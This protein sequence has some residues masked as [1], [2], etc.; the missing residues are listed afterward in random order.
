MARQGVE[1]F[2][3]PF[4]ADAVFLD[5]ACGAGDLLIAIA[6]LLP[7]EQ[8]LGNTLTKWGQQLAGFDI[9]PGFI[10]ATKARLVLTALARGAR[11]GN[12]PI[13]AG[14]DLFP[15]ICNSHDLI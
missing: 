14:D 9:E 6:N 11:T 8:D 10:Q 3:R 2:D 12:T 13:P 1:F 4:P 15:L 7:V 5:V